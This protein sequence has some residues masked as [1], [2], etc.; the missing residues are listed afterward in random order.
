MVDEAPR[1]A[2]SRRRSQRTD[3]SQSPALSS[4]LGEWSTASKPPEAAEL[5]ISGPIEVWE[6]SNNR[7]MREN[8]VH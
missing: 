7:V 6:G 5:C 1:T 4:A 3:G 2:S 8:I